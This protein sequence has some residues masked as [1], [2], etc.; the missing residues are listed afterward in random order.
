MYMYLHMYLW[1]YIY[2]YKG[3]LQAKFWRSI[4]GKIIELDDGFSGKD[5]PIWQPSNMACR[6]NV[7]FPSIIH[8]SLNK[9][10]ADVP[11]VPHVFAWFPHL[12]TPSRVK[13]HDSYDGSGDV[14]HGPRN[15]RSLQRHK[16][17][18]SSRLGR[19]LPRF[20]AEKASQVEDPWDLN[21]MMGKLRGN[22]YCLL[23]KSMVSDIANMNHLWKILC[24]VISLLNPYLCG[25]FIS[26][27]I[28][29]I[30]P[31]AYGI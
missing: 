10:I 14:R 21:W 8:P 22:P 2:I 20:R 23:G 26:Y 9:I 7:P 25:I 17:I 11:S 3:N 24:H 4:A 19:L 13:L 5:V 16:Q 12:S 29:F 1:C 31:C 30:S 28:Q 6:T 18:A 27:C 15:K